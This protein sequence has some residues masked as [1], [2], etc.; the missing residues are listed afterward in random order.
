MSC[1]VCGA[2]C[3]CRKAGPGG[4]CCGCHKHKSQRGFS[5]DQVDRWRTSHQLEAISGEQWARQ[6]VEREEPKLPIP[7]P[8]AP[9]PIA[10]NAALPFEGK[11]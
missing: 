6:Y 7:D 5:R 4:M 10:R 8:P 1:P 2:N 11:S 9:A 3:R